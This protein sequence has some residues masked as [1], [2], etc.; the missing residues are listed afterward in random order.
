MFLRN[1]LLAVG[2]SA[3]LAGLVLL[4]LWLRQPAGSATNIVATTEIM[5]AAHPIAT[6]TLLATDDI[7]WKAINAD[8]VPVGGFEREHTKQTDLMGA[9][10]E[11]DVAEGEPILSTAI[12]RP[13]DHGFLSAVLRPGYRAVSIAVEAPQSSSGLLRPG[14]HVDVILTQNFGD[15]SSDPGQRSVGETVLHDVRIVAVDQSLNPEAQKILSSTSLTSV[16]Q[17]IPRTITFE[18]IEADAQKLF[19]A[20][21]LGK[22][23][24]A[25]RAMG[26]AKDDVT[27]A[28]PAWASDV[29][30]ALRM[31]GSRTRGTPAAA[32]AP[33]S[34]TAPRPGLV[35]MRG[36]KV[37]A[38]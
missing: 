11:R 6:G 33:Q 1:V 27:S 29:S 36:A 15:L 24:V 4:G 22:V 28:P 32:V 18:V 2:I 20:V 34:P 30:P 26:G 23:E 8:S 19:V 7:G 10:M 5:V 31:L 17:R 16:D 38:H 9:L 25:V 14:D 3:S 35:I 13:S 12:L 21:Q 37:E